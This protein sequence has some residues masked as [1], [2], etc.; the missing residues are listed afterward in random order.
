MGSHQS[1]PHSAKAAQLAQPLQAGPVVQREGGLQA[2]PAGR[3]GAS[4]LAEVELVEGEDV[5]LG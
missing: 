2:R 1:E 4:R 3:G 5:F